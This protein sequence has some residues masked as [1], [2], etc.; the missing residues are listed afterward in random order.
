[1]PEMFGFVVMEKRAGG[2]VTT[3]YDALGSARRV[4]KIADRMITCD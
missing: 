1:M 2:W 4:C 3:T